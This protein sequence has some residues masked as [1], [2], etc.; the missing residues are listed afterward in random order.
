MKK[1][2]SLFAFALFAVLG[3]V[4]TRA[5]TLPG[6]DARLLPASPTSADNLKLSIVDRS[7]TGSFPY[8]ANSYRVTM[9]QNNITVTLGETE[10]NHFDLPSGT[11]GRN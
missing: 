8:K 2:I 5:Q 9:V 11:P 4:I 6:V 7:C 10:R 1:R 3:T